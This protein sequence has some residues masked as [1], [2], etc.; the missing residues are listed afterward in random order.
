MPSGRRKDE[1]AERSE[2][3]VFDIDVVVAFAVAAVD[4]TAAF[5]VFELDLLSSDD[6]AAAA[7][8]F[9][10]CGKATKKR[11]NELRVETRVKMRDGK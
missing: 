2:V 3:A 9:F 6:A 1:E 5:S 10:A 7:E 11:K 8:A 4:S